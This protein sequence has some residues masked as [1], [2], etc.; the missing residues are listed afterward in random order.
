M[1]FGSGLT[2]G[3]LI[4]GGRPVISGWAAIFSL[5]FLIWVWMTARGRGFGLPEVR[6]VS[7]GRRIPRAVRLSRIGISSSRLKTLWVRC[8]FAKWFARHADYRIESA[9]A[10]I[11]MYNRSEA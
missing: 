2:E 6:P 4:A 7:V 11:K 10:I 1:M 8:G 9:D 3:I 5:I